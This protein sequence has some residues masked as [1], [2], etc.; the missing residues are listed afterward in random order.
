V[1]YI[2]GEGAKV[3][4][5]LSEGFAM[6][7]SK[8]LGTWQRVGGPGAYVLLNTSLTSCWEAHTGPFRMERPKIVYNPQNPA[9]S[10]WYGAALV[11]LNVF[12]FRG[13]CLGCRELVWCTLPASRV[14]WFHIDTASFG[15]SSVGV[16]TA[17]SVEGP[18]NFVTCFKPDGQNSYGES[19]VGTPVLWLHGLT[20]VL[21]PMILGSAPCVPL[22]FL[23]CVPCSHA[24]DM[25]LFH[26]V[27]GSAYLVRSVN[28]RFAGISQLTPDFLNTTAAG[29][30]SS[31]PDCEGQAIFRVGTPPTY[32]L[33]GR[34]RPQPQWLREGRLHVCNVL[35]GP[36]AQA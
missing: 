26:D 13:W 29:I 4:E 27:D 9:D 33:L 19:C 12:A 7:K 17:S 8:D 31:G 3:Y 15:I 20:R 16:T 34:Y 5:D 6:Y 10:Q 23:C 14:M 36:E 28:N 32:Y 35:L 24:A 22:M 21:H 2:V 11:G 18:Y 1:Y 25:G 30:I